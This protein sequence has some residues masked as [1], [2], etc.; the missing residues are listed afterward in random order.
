MAHGQGAGV[1]REPTMLTEV[2]P[3]MIAFLEIWQ[4]QQ[5]RDPEANIWSAMLTHCLTALAHLIQA[6][7]MTPAPAVSKAQEAPMPNTVVEAPIPTT[8]PEAPM[9]T[10]TVQGQAPLFPDALVFQVRSK[11]SVTFVTPQQGDKPLRQ[12][13]GPTAP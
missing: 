7:L 11:D 1:G 8:D 13:A 12:P 2:S 4:I 6:C 3:G 9:P 5:A 10:N